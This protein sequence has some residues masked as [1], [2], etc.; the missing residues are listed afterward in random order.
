MTG[1]WTTDGFVMV[2]DIQITGE[3][4]TLEARRRFVTAHYP[5]G[6]RL[7]PDTKKTR[8]KKTPRLDI[9]LDL[10][11]TNPAP[12]QA[13]AAL[14]KVF[15]TTQ[16][17]FVELVPDY[18]KPCVSGGLSGKDTPCHFSRELIAIPGV[19]SPETNPTHVQSVT[20]P[21]SL[22]NSIFH[23][24][25]GVTPPKAIFSPEPKFSEAARHATFQGVVTLGVQV[26]STGIPRNVRILSPIGVGLDQ[27]AV[28][29]V[30]GWRFKPAVKDGHPVAVEIAVEVD[31]HLN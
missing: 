9:E 28:L 6:F 4:I 2:N 24:G 12:G 26:D 16:D 7:V 22:E 13:E 5:D 11:Q 3:R 20:E 1:D 19:S 8:K 29:A 15:L 30:Q 31:F 17:A 23:V 10:G 21:I 27:K 14:S 18:W 25:K